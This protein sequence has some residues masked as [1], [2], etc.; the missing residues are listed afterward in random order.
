MKIQELTTKV[1][2][3]ASEIATLQQ[4]LADACE[5]IQRFSS[6]VRGLKRI[7]RISKQ[8]KADITARL[9]TLFA[10]AENKFVSVEDIIPALSM[11][12]G[13][14]NVQRTEVSFAFRVLRL[15]LNKLIDAAKTAYKSVFEFSVAPQELSNNEIEQLRQPAR[16]AYGRELTASDLDFMQLVVCSFASLC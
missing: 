5:D 3:Q 9:R 12:L 13:E 2:K 6:S 16:L 8:S 4:I 14:Q 1:S 15:E 10:R 7:Q 11:A